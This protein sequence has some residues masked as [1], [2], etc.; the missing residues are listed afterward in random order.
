[1]PRALA[2]G[3]SMV[4][5]PTPARTMRLRCLPASMAWA[6][7]SVARTTRIPTPSRAPGSVSLVSSGRETIST[8]RTR[9]SSSAWV[10]ILSAIRRHMRLATLPEKRSAVFREPDPAHLPPGARRE[11]VP[12]ARPEVPRR[13]EAGAA[14]QHQLV[15]HELPVVLAERPGGGAEAGVGGVG[16][17]GPL[18]HVAEELPRLRWCGALVQ[19]QSRS[20]V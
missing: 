1:M 8:P 7:T 3:T 10:S 14:A 9:S 15:A 18:P 16:A 13:A 6:V 17:R 5:S 19:R 4:L 20:R 12:V 2:A 11:K